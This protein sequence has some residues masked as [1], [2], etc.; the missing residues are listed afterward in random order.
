MFL[1]GA[2]GIETVSGVVAARAGTGGVA[3]AV[4][5]GLEET[6]ELAAVA[7]AMVTLLRHLVDRLEGRPVVVTDTSA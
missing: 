4:A 1:T 2:L 5:S 7:L 3:Y 6:V